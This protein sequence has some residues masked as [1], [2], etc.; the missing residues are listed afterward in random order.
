MYMRVM[1]PETISVSS[2]VSRLEQ[3][4]RDTVKILRAVINSRYYS[5]FVATL[6]GPEAGRFIKILDR[7]SLRLDSPY[8][9]SR[10][11]CD[12]GRL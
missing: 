3:N 2:L 8:F 4:E 12:Y 9:T 7:V 6:E 5:D 10:L 1:Y 11:I